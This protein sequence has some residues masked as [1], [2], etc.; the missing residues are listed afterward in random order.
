MIRVTFL[1][2]RKAELD[3]EQFQKYWREQHG[4]L[5]ASHAADLGMLRYVQVHGIEDPI[6]E[7]MA[8]ARGGME[9]PY[10]GVA[11]V[12]FENRDVLTEVLQTEAGQ[13]AAAALL[14]DEARFIDLPR[15]PLWLGYE[16]PQVNPS[17]ET[18]VARPHNNVVKLYFPLRCPEGMDPEAA[19]FYWRT[20]HGPIIRRHAPASGMLRYLQ[21]HRAL[22]DELEAALREPRGTE[23][24]PYL[25]H[26]EVWID[27]SLTGTSPER[28][29]ANRAAI[30]DEANFI[31]F[32][33]SA[34]W[35]GKEHVFVDHR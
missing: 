35:L 26:A 27:R 16:Y 13:Q 21:V 31:D 29:E 30:E 7:A 32:K 15:S 20:R 8:K 4:P 3:R 12:W 9:A 24:A 25:G 11:E 28:R 17:P 18:L 1:L 22:D 6:N 5:V 23:V 14:E 34:M 33:R 10:D 19:Q 2:R